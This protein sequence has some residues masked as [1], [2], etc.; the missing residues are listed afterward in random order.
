MDVK[1]SKTLKDVSHYKNNY[2]IKMT[3]KYKVK[4]QFAFYKLTNL[5]GIFCYNTLDMFE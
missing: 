4:A 5:K 1:H 2:M 3:H